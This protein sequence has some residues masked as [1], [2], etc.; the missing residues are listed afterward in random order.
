MPATGPTPRRRA[1]GEGSIHQ[2]QE[3]GRWVGRITVGKNA[4][5]GQARKKVTGSTRTEVAN[6]IR[7]LLADPTNVG[8]TGRPGA[9][10]EV[11][12]N[13]L[14]TAAPA[15]QATS[16][17]DRTTDRVEGKIIPALGRHRLDELR[18]DHIERWFQAEARA[19]RAPATIQDYRK[20]LNQILTWAVA[21][22]LIR[23]NPMQA[24]TMP[25]TE[26][27]TDKRSLTRGEA[28]AL[29]A[30]LETERHGPYFT[31]VLALGLRPGEADALDWDHVDFDARTLH[32]EHSLQR[33][34][35]G[36]PAVI[37]P[38]KTKSQRS[39][40]MSP[41]VEAALRRQ[42]A[43][44]DDARSAAGPDWS[45]RWPRPLVFTTELGD[46]MW[47]SN[48]R[49]E[50]DRACD[51]AGIARITPY[52]LRHTAASLLIDDGADRYDV[53]D[54]L[55]H[56]DT[57]MLERHYRHRLTP[58]VTRGADRLASLLGTDSDRTA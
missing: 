56:A 25:R 42:R 57:R 13:W 17:L 47:S 38:T 6:R 2:D 37:G 24:V 36:R 1:R 51:K 35:G 32:I 48:L 26:R 44:Q 14:Q 20:T 43:W 53:A 7:A 19:G 28:D 16:T 5:G 15:R 31:T 8:G 50:F 39:L 55:G 22:Q 34:N 29:L 33:L 49:R 9:V 58:A 12:C 4:Q 10:A 11:A 18:T 46:P 45:V 21:R 27:A 30:V 23:W 52:E 40:P 41:R 3:T 54:L